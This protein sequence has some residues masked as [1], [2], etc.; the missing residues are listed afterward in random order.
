M[1]DP[2]ALWADPE[3]DPEPDD[4]PDPEPEPAVALAPEPEPA[5]ALAPEPEDEP[6]EELDADVTLD[7]L[8]PVDPDPSLLSTGARMIRS[9]ALT[10]CRGSACR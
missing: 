2:P 5:L 9:A 10:S 1:D 6:E 7:E 4:E 8:L 3:P